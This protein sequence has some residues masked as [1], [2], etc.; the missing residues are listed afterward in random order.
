MTDQH[1][2]PVVVAPSEDQDEAAV[3]M[4]AALLEEWSHPGR[5][6]T[7]NKSSVSATLSLP[8]L[9]DLESALA[10]NRTM[11]TST[12]ALVS[13]LRRKLGGHVGWKM[14]WKG[15]F[16]ERPILCGPLFGCGLLRSDVSNDTKEPTN[17][18]LSKYRAFAAE[19]EFLFVLRHSL[20]P[21]I[22]GEKYNQEEVWDAVDRIELCIEL[23]GARQFDSTNKFH[24]IADA[25]CSS[26]VV[27]GP[28]I[29]TKEEI[30][31]PSS[32]V[33]YT[34]ELFLGD[35][36]ISSGDAT[37]NPGDSPLASVTA[38]VNELCVERGM[39]LEAGAVVIC[40]HCCQA[41]FAGRPSPPLGGKPR[42]EWGMASWKEGDILRAKFGT[43]GEVKV[44][45]EP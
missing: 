31:D 45:L 22:N 20:N 15:A 16:P 28:C 41:Q 32:L 38:L 37:N 1:N 33:K 42:P 2:E 12:N 39:T 35:T 23:C 17:A 26:A 9:S 18:S 10:V 19:A 30:G 36:R 13:D 27:R 14:G 6:G 44:T 11:V 21:R 4:A 29:G 34:V 7:G 43:L 5:I 24:Y 25:L 3:S 8:P 40:G